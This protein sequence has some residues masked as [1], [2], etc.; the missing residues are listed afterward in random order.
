MTKLIIKSKDYICWTDQLTMMMPAK[1][2]IKY[3]WKGKTE[4]P[5]TI[6]NEKKKVWSY[7][8]CR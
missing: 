5:T 8:W 7:H 3:R 4:T 2:G 6:G 1:M